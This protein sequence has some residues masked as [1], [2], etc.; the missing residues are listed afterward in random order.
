MES[1]IRN[2]FLTLLIFFLFPLIWKSGMAYGQEHG[3]VVNGAY[4]VLNGGDESTPV[5]LVVDQPATS[6]I[7][8]QNGGHIDSEGQYNFIKWITEET[9]GEFVFPFGVGGNSADYIPFIFNKTSGESANVSLSTWATDQQNL[10]YPGESNVPAVTEMSGTAEAITAAIDRFWDIRT[11][12]EITADLTFSY[13][14]SENTT[15]LPVSNFMAQHWNGSSWDPQVGPGSPGVLTG[16]GSVGPILD[17]S[18]FSPWVLTSSPFTVTIDSAE[19]LICFGECTGSAHVSEDGGVAPYTY[20]W[21]TNPI[22][23]TETATGLCPGDYIVTVTDAMGNTATDSI[24]IS[25]SPELSANTS[26]LNADCNTSCNG[27]ATINASGGIPDYTYSWNTEPVQLTDTATDL[28]AGTYEYSVVD[29]MGCTFTGLVNIE[30]PSPI[31]IEISSTPTGCGSDNGTATA[32]P[33]G[34]TAPYIYL[35]SDGQTTQTATE[36]SMGDYTV[37]ITDSNDCDMNASVS[38][39]ESEGP[40]I[41]ITAETIH[42]IAGEST[43][44]VVTGGSIYEW[45]PDTEMSC[46]DCSDPTVTPLETTT[47]CVQVSDENGCSNNECITIHV[48]LPPCEVFVPNAFSPNGDGNNDLQCVLG[49]CIQSQSFSFLLY[50]RWGE[51]VFESSDPAACW[52]GT[53]NGNPLNTAVFVYYLK[54]TLTNG[55][56]ITKSGNVSLIR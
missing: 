20:S 13:R 29:S 3:L 36:L 22:Q 9:T 12:S 44:L 53:F 41:S 49:D 38:I 39:V 34:G 15:D 56:E 45:N 1:K 46:T 11:S 17:Q 37:I 6:G 4:I 26:Q 16:I 19:D 2:S 52:D 31:S 21:N 27:S 40:E 10:P 5:Y 18:T 35:W 14:A 23:S 48:E 30:E 7:E 43:E 51:K 54:A 55:E 33:V 32:T 47:Y 8:R 28:C 42:L 25:E 24:T 50:N